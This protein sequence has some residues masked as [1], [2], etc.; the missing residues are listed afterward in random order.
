MNRALFACAL[1]APL[2]LIT[3][4]T[5]AD[6]TIY[7]DRAEF[8]AAA[9]LL[10]MVIDEGYESYADDPHA[11]RTI[12]LNQFDV[13]YDL[14]GDNSDFGVSN[15]LDLP[16]GIGPTA[17]NFFLRAEYPS[18]TVPSASVTFTFPGAIQAFGTDIRDLENDGLNFAATPVPPAF[19]SGG[20]QRASSSSAS[21]APALFP[22]LAS[23]NP[24]SATA[25]ASSSAKQ[26]TSIVPPCSRTFAGSA[27]LSARVA[28]A[29]LSSAAAK[30]MGASF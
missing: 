13:T 6:V 28:A 3:A 12:H 8:N 9:S 14:N 27:S 19:G 22:P 5:S 21:S 18:V 2:F 4:A 25:T 23:P 17:G 29:D 20:A 10:G 24:A 16:N 26:C 15:E 11:G 30:I 1:C 7:H